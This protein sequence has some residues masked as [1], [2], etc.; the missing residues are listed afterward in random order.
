MSDLKDKLTKIQ[1]A[2]KGIDGVHLHDIRNFCD[3]NLSVN[4]KGVLKQIGRVH[5]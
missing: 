1:E 3:G 4:K 2:L 5:V